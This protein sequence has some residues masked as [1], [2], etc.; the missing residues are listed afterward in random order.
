MKILTML[1][2]CLGAFGVLLPIAL[3]FDEE[4]LSQ[5]GSPGKPRLTLTD[6]LREE[7]LRPQLEADAAILFHIINEDMKITA[8]LIEGRL[9]L[10]AAAD[11]MRALHESKPAHLRIKEDLPPEQSVE[12]YFVRRAFR[13]AER[14]LKDD[15]HRDAIL[16]RLQA[17]LDDYLYAQAVR[18]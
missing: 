13:G 6:W 5:Q 8:E 9:S 16:A 12:E 4:V 11:A 18:P 10:C 15:P 2:L 7:R 3:Y 1:V 14:D 17:E